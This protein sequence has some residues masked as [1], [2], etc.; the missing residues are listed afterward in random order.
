MENCGTRGAPSQR[1]THLKTLVKGGHV[2]FVLHVAPSLTLS[3]S[4]VRQPKNMA[5]CRHP[6]ILPMGAQSALPARTAANQLARNTMSA[7][8]GS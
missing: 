7:F 5:F 4:R 1:S 6:Y 2:V 8:G 3:Q